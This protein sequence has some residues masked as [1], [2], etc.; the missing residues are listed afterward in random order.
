MDTSDARPVPTGDDHP[1]ELVEGHR[2]AVEGGVGGRHGGGERRP[3]CH[4]DEGA[5]HAGHAQPRHLEDVTVGQRRPVQ[6]SAGV[7][8]GATGHH[9]ELGTARP[10]ADDGQAVVLEC[11]QQA[12]HR[13]AARVDGGP[14]D[15]GGGARRGRQPAPPYPHESVRADGTGDRAV[16]PP[17]S[18]QFCPGEDIVRRHRSD[19]HASRRR[20]GP[21]LRDGRPRGRGDRRER[22]WQQSSIRGSNGG[23]SRPGLWIEGRAVD[24]SGR[25][26]GDAVTARNLVRIRCEVK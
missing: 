8:T 3:P 14:V 19:D 1:I 4:V 10:T 2:S 26:S 12:E 17:A 5:R 15:R 13:A 18:V 20:F 21:R 6:F 24:G 9:G 7:R 11:A 16:R 25:G 23:R 22:S